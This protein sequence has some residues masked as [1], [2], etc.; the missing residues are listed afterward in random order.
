MED[1]LMVQVSFEELEFLRHAY[2]K[3]TA[4]EAAGVDNWEGYGIAM[5][6]LYDMVKG[7][8]E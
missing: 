5:D 7:D 6:I 4:L 8:E 2:D 1:K 3:L